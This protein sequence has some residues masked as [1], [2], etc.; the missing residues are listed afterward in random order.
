MLGEHETA[1]S[2]NGRVG[3]KAFM[4]LPGYFFLNVFFRFRSGTVY[5]STYFRKIRRCAMKKINLK[6]LAFICISVMSLILA[7]GYV[8][9]ADDLTNLTIAEVLLWN[10]L[11]NNLSA[12]QSLIGAPFQVVGTPV[13][14]KGVGGKAIGTLDDNSLLLMPAKDFFGDEKREGTVSVFLKKGKETLVPYKSPLPCIFGGQLYDFQTKWCQDAPLKNPDGTCT[15]LAITGCWGDGESLPSGLVLLFIDSDETHHIA[16]DT[17][18]NTA[19]VPVGQWVHIMFVW[20]IRGIKG[21]ADTLRIYRDGKLVGK[22]SAP[23]K[24]PISLP[25]PV[26]V[27]GNHAAYR[28]DG[29]ILL[30]DEIMVFNRAVTP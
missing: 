16:V 8:S 14:R 4:A 2:K 28:N 3:E 26:A 17:A 19:A 9:F 27:A 13:W 29:P 18:F 1:W 20:D 11:D 25:T 21:S 15:N 23:I 12:M 24:N 6:K 7:Q 30:C 5:H 22:Y 10:K